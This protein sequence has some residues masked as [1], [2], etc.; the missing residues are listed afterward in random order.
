[1]ILNELFQHFYLDFK[2]KYL[3][4]KKRKGQYIESQW[5]LIFWTHFCIVC[6]KTI[7]AVI[8]TKMKFTL[9]FAQ[10]LLGVFDFLLSDESNQSYIK[11]CPGSSKLYNGSEWM[12]FFS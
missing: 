11:T 4:K 6:T 8:H 1:M 3:K 7:K 2:G 10:A 9:W 5:G 12:L